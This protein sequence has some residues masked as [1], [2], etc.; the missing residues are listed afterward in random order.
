[1]KKKNILTAVLSLCLVAVITVGATL[2]YFTDKSEAVHNT[3]TTGNIKIAV[4]DETDPTEG[5]VGG[6]KDPVTGDIAY[7]TETPIMPGDVISKQVSVSVD[8]GSQPAWVA[9]KLTTNVSLSADSDLNV[10]EAN[11][12]VKALIDQ[13]V[14]K[15]SAWVEDENNEGVYYY[16]D[17]VQPGDTATPIFTTLTI[18]GEAWGNDY[19]GMTFTIN[20]EAAA[21][22]AANIDE[23]VDAKTELGKLFIEIS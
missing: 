23:F 2:A 5:Q 19:A 8:S 12:A 11:A 9:L 6:V 7:G 3:F 22:Q 21:V 16:Q 14:A 15:Q 20:V 4:V 10:D 13:E 18:P 17:I 1:M